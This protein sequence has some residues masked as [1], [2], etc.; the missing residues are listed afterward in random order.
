MALTST[1][2]RGAWSVLSALDKGSE[3]MDAT[4]VRAA[5]EALGLY[6]GTAA[7]LRGVTERSWGRWEV[8]H[9]PPPADLEQWLRYREIVEREL[10]QLNLEEE[11]ALAV[12]EALWD[13]TPEVWERP[14]LWS[15]LASSDLE[16]SREL[17]AK[18]RGAGAGT[19]WAVVDALDRARARSSEPDL[20]V[21]REV[22]LA[23][24]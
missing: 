23:R 7:E 12:A 4:D 22:G 14:T 11:E 6:Q 15:V 24:R 21:L 9:V 2:P 5:R 8:G 18:V 19:T 3:I 17:I 13:W 1:R 16:L 20:D 10:G